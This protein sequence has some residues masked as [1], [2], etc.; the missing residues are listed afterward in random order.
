MMI[1]WVV[2]CT[3]LSHGF[4]LALE[5]K[6]VAFIANIVVCQKFGLKIEKF[7]GSNW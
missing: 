4:Q 6:N 3:M 5:L 7:P 1:R 2:T